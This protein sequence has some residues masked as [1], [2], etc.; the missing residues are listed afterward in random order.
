MN[1]TQFFLSYL[2]NSP[3][4]DA[5]HRAACAPIQCSG[6]RPHSSPWHHIPLW[7]INNNNN[8]NSILYKDSLNLLVRW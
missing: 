3:P 1:G 7:N 8:I 4:S 2:D 5:T 6:Y